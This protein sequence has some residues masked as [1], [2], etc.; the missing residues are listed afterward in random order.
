MQPTAV[1][2]I[3][4][5]SQHSFKHVGF[6]DVVL[7]CQITIF[8]QYWLAAVLTSSSTS[9]LSYAWSPGLYRLDS[10]CYKTKLVASFLWHMRTSIICPYVFRA[11]AAVVGATDCVHIQKCYDSCIASQTCTANMVCKQHV[12]LPGFL[13]TAVVC[14]LPALLRVRYCRLMLLEKQGCLCSDS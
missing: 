11:T 10:P 3:A 2:R 13:L 14:L 1:L 8:K 12:A 9:A 7:F 6:A 4:M 5:C